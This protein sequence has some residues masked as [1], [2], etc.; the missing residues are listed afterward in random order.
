M[1]TMQVHSELLGAYYRDRFNVDFRS[2]RWVL[3][4]RVQLPGMA[5]H[6]AGDCAGGTPLGMLMTL[7]FIKAVRFI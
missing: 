5:D 4:A 3:W 2:L 6:C 7:S 1:T